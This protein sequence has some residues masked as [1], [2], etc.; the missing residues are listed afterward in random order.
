MPDR[1]A[2]AEGGGAPRASGRLRSRNPDR[3][4]RGRRVRG[5][6]AWPRGAPPA[7]PP[8]GRRAFR[9]L[10]LRRVGSPPGPASRSPRM[11]APARGP[12]RWAHPARPARDPPGPRLPPHPRHPGSARTARRRPAPGREAGREQRAARPPAPAGAAH[13]PPALPTADAPEFQ[14][15]FRA[16]RPRDP[17]PAPPLAAAARTRRQQVWRLQPGPPRPPRAPRRPRPPAGSRRRHRRPPARPRRAPSP[18]HKEWVSGA[19][20]PLGAGE[21]PPGRAAPER[22]RHAPGPCAGRRR[23]DRPRGGGRRPAS[24]WW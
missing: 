1:R 18:A 15:Y 12:R 3:G 20:A 11:A 16:P 7:A 5:A 2:R 9:F 14:S 4:L 10:P 22:G 6:A 24:P 8:C 19:I 17:G 23:A 21:V 13:A